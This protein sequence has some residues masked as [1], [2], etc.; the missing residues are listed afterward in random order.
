[1]DTSKCQA[2]QTSDQM[3]CS[4]DNVW[5]MNDPEPPACRK[6]VVVDQVR[7]TPVSA[8]P[9]V[10]R[11]PVY[12]YRRR[13][14]HDFVTCDR[15]RYA[16]LSAKPHLFETKVLYTAPQ[17]AKQ[18]PAPDVAGLVEALEALLA[19]RVVEADASYGLAY[20]KAEQALAAH[21]KQGG[22]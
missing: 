20:A 2:R 1:M 8:A 4:C 17:P 9:A 12:L 21:R 5:D 7:T 13:G 11:E 3:T 19:V 14:L 6:A 22:E 18:Q 10:Q 15:E 16:E